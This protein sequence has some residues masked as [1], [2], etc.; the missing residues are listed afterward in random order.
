MFDK[1]FMDAFVAGEAEA[2]EYN[3][4]VEWWHKSEKSAW[5]TLREGLG[6]TKEEYAEWLKSGNDSEEFFEALKRR[7]L[8]KS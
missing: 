1:T 4:Y 3:D 5:P 7:R 2:Y 6:L 8:E